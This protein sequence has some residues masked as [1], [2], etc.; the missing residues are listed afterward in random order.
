MASFQYIAKDAN[1]NEVSGTY[2]DVVSVID[3]KNELAKMGYALV[4]ANRQRFAAINKNKR[5]KPSEIVEFAYEF[6]AM[7]GSGLSIVKSLTTIESQTENE[8][9]ISIVSDVRQRVEEGA[10]LKEAFEKYSDIFTVFFISMIEA[11]EIGGKLGETLYMAAEYLEKQV[12]L[13]KRIK[14]AFTYPI[15]VSVMCMI[16]VSAIVI[17]VVPVFQKLYNSLHVSLPGPTM[18]LIW[19]S[20]IVH[21]FWWV[22]LAGIAVLIYGTRYVIKLDSVKIKLDIVKLRMPLL[23]RLNKMIVTSRF[24][25]TFA[26]MCS[27]G[28]SVIDSLELAGRV[29]DNHQVEMM[30]RQIGKKVMTGSSLAEPMSEYNIFPPMMVELAGVGEEAGMLPEMLMKGV[31]FLDKKIEKAI[32]SLIVK[33]EPILS[34]FMGTLVGLILLAVYLPMFDYMGQVK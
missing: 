10:T 32:T 16:I 19:A 33:I 20:Q 30:S 8:A 9:L 29:A 17:F 26:M 2:T 4:R 13:K 5:L 12:D 31:G 34:V 15:V 28:I 1:G 24:I 23:G 11:G 14:A 18:A 7:Y 22:V 27:A 3:L 25:R 6:A 21:Q